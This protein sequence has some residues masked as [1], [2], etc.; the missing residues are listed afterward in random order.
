MAG[1]AAAAQAAGPNVEY[2]DFNYVSGSIFK[3]T[4][5]YMSHI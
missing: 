5:G 2:A 1:A 3:I 4:A